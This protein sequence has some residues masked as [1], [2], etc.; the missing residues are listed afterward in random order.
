VVITYF[1]ILDGQAI[2]KKNRKGDKKEHK[3]NQ[4]LPKRTGKC[5]QDLK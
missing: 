5:L 2:A 3:E 4:A 1:F